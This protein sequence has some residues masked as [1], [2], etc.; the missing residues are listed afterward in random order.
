MIKLLESRLVNL[1]LH[2]FLIS[3][4]RER[5][6]ACGVSLLLGTQRYVVDSDLTG[7]K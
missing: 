6:V 5:I 4:L 2:H 7:L 1:I 3:F